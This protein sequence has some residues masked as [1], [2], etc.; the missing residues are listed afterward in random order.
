MKR[1]VEKQLF[2]PLTEECACPGGSRGPL[3]TCWESPSGDSTQAAPCSHTSPGVPWE[4]RRLC[5][6]L[7]D[8]CPW[9]WLTLISASSWSAMGVMV[10]SYKAGRPVGSLAARGPT[11][12]GKLGCHAALSAQVFALP[13]C[14]APPTP[15]AACVSWMFVPTARHPHWATGFPGPAA[16]GRP[17]APARSGRAPLPT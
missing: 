13:A 15:E 14:P 5:R 1:S 3:G 6:R 12:G 10:S 4:P 9:L 2:H 7:C 16:V 8:A 11:F 17:L